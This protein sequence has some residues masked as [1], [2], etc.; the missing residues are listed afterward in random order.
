MKRCGIPCSKLAVLGEQ[1]NHPAAT[2]MYRYLTAHQVRPIRAEPLVYLAAYCRARKEHALAYLYSKA[3]V[4]I[5]MPDD[6]LYVDQACYK[7]RAHQEY[8]GA[9]YNTF[10]FAEA[11]QA[12]ED[13][14][15]RPGLLPEVR[16][17]TARNLKLAMEAVRAQSEG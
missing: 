5:P 14:L 13:L 11:C 16:E 8:A 17:R 7:W 12:Y 4:Q 6:L 2:V 1:L 15:N 10:R 9:C 3:G